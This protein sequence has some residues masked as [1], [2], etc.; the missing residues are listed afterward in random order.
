MG[1]D[2]ARQRIVRL[3]TEL[4]PKGGDYLACAVD[5]ESRP[6]D[7]QIE[8]GLAVLGDAL[9]AT[10]HWADQ[11]KGIQQAVAQC[12][13]ARSLLGSVGLLCK[14]ACPHQPLKEL[15]RRED[16]QIGTGGSA[17]CVDIIAEKG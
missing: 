2:Q 10:R 8:P 14:A 4:L 7:R 9:A 1:L 12:I 13:A 17:Q 6:Q 11:A 15:Q 3:L 16:P 5:A